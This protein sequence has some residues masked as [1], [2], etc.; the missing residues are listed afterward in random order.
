MRVHHLNCATLC[1]LGGRSTGG[2]GGPL[3]AGRLVCHC[4]LVESPAGLVLIDTGLGAGDLAN[5][6]RLGRGFLA[7]TRPLLDEAE[8]AVRQ[9][10]RLGLDPRDVRHV[11]LTH[12]DPDHAGALGDF[13]D[14]TV[15]VYDAEYRAA[16]APSLR[17]APRY[18][19]AQWAHG[20]AWWPHHVGGDRWFGF[21]CVRQLEGLPP[22]FA[23]IPLI[24][25]TRGHAGVAVQTSSGWLL[26]AGDAYFSRHE[27]RTPGRGGELL[28]AV[29]Y[30][31]SFDNA[32]RLRNRERLRRLVREHGDEVRVFCAHDPEE[33][34]ELRRAAHAPPA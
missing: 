25:H 29:Q 24:G 3:S 13:A 20:P 8:P 17:E 2:S 6:G 9:I 19:V 34:D 18:R 21:T 26:H 16:T 32:E 12:L 22:E 23:M 31:D 30:L 14:A 27:L 5:P 15:H 28:R 10:A 7:L 1:P 33:F 11:V 4:L